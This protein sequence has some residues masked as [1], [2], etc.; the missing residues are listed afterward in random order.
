[1]KKTIVAGLVAG[2]V[3][4]I[5]GM[6]FGSFTAD[7]Y[8]MSPASLWKPMGGSWFG[9]MIIYD[10]IFGLILSYVFS[11]ISSVIP[12]KGIQKGLIFGLL[13][14]LAGSVPG[15]GITYLTMNIR[16]KLIL[17]WLANGLANYCL[18]GAAI[19]VVDEKLK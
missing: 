14:W 1:M 6:I 13:L 9:Q 8:K 10:I 15:L 2:I 17:M 4:L 18:A 7:M 12:G 19:Q 5:V 11:V 16:N 3:I